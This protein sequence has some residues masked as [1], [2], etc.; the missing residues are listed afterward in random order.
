MCTRQEQSRVDPGRGVALRVWQ[1]TGV[2][3][4]RRRTTVVVLT[5]DAG[6]RNARQDCQKA[7]D[8]DSDNANDSDKASDDDDDDDKRQG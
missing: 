3:G 5:R 4:R 6:G 1:L 7:G 2:V 8:S